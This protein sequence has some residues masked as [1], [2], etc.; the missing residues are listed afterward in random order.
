MAHARAWTAATDAASAAA[1]RVAEAWAGLSTEAQ[2]LL[3]GGAGVA[4][5]AYLGRISLRRGGGGGDDEFSRKGEWGFAR[6]GRQRRFPR[7]AHPARR[8][9][10]GQRRGP[11]A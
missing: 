2:L 5:E 6:A 7:F 3:I 8:R 10:A 11:L 1:R 9:R 4:L